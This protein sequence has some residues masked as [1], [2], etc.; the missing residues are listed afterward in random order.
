MRLTNSLIISLIWG[1][2]GRKMGGEFVYKKTRKG[3]KIAGM[4]I[5]GNAN[6]VVAYPLPKKLGKKLKVKFKDVI[7]VEE[8]TKKDLKDG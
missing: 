5:A 7:I 8:V 2:E 6:V 3:M 4:V 1:K